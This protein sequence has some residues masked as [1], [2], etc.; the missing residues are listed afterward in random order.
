MPQDG[1][2]RAHQELCAIDC[3]MVINPD[4]VEAYM[5]EGIAW[6]LTATLNAAITIENGRVQ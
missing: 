5:E 2:V 3:G 6:G 1:T 4:K